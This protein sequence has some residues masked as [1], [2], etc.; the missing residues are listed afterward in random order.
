MAAGVAAGLIVFAR[1]LVVT[2]LHDLV[3][4]G[5]WITIDLS[6]IALSAGAFLFCVA[7]YLMGLKEFK[8]MARTA[9]YI[10]LIGYSM[11]LLCL[12]LDIGRPD[13]FYYG[14]IHWN[15]HSVMWEVTMCI[16]LY[17]IVLVFENLPTIARFSWLQDKFPKLAG[18]ME[19]IHNYAL[20]LAIAGLFLS[21]LHQSSLGA[22]YG[23]LI[24]RP[25]WFRPGLATLFIISAGAGGIALTTLATWVVSRLNRNITIKEELL[26]KT[27]R[28]LG[29][30]LVGYLYLRFW[31]VFSMTYTFQPGR[32]EGLN[33]LTQGPLSF[34]FWVGEIFLGIAFPLV[35]L[36]STRLRSNKIL[37]ALALI[38]IVGGVVAY[39]WDTN[40][41]GQLIVQTPFSIDTAPLFTNYFPSIIEFVAAAGIIA[42]GMLAFTLGVKHLSVVD[43]KAEVEPVH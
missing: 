33:L 19:G 7:V 27:S 29:W 3:P 35:I 4:W 43:H 6:A 37:R 39:R 5:L 25:I 40:L 2:N 18:W 41:V 22:A 36:L 32:A 34:N 12:L 10:G 26:D 42:F 15:T 21:M 38:S 14:F 28:F 23:V 13:R 11:A 20:Y 24:A 16:G 1:G 9:A 31:D 8:P 17:F 30:W